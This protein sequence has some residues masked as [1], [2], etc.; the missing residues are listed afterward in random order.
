MV[1]LFE[2]L[3]NTNNT[4]ID[5]LL[6]DLDAALTFM[7]VAAVSGIGET[8]KRNYENAYHAYRTVLRL[9]DKLDPDA[10]QRAVINHKLVLLKERL[11]QVG[12]RSE[13]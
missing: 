2:L 5:F 8:K 13:L 3:R 11:E 9:L 10:A 7:D 6:T 1:D 12:Y 4:G